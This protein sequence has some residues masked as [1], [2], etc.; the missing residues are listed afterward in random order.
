VVGVADPEWGNRVVAVVVG[1]LSLDDA[2][3]WVGEKHPRSWAPREVVVVPEIPML[4]NG[5]VDRLA[6][7]TLAGASG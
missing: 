3:A 4:T 1:E 5:K 7:R 2:R 6:V